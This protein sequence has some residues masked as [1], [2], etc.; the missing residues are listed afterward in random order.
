MKVS[1]T[2]KESNGIIHTKRLVLEPFDAKHECYIDTLVNWLNDQDIMCYSDQRHKVHTHESACQY[3][4][5]FIGSTN[6]YW[7]IL[8]DKSIIGTI[9]AYIDDNNFVADIGVLIGSKLYGGCGYGSEAFKAVIEW[10][11]SSQNIYKITAGTMANNIPMLRVMEK[12]GMH[13]ESRKEK[14]YMFNGHRVD[15][16]CATIFS[17]N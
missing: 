4:K 3:Y 8:N 15:M 11:F 14:Y 1:E 10:L 5:S 16:I 12:C 6:H 9:T 13:Q 17:G 2:G 7:I